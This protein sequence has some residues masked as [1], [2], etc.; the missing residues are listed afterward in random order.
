MPQRESARRSVSQI[1][2][3]LAFVHRTNIVRYKKLLMSDLSDDDRISVLR[4]LAEEEAAL[5]Q[6]NCRGA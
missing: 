1:E 3:S 4:R 2:A 6:F 5:R